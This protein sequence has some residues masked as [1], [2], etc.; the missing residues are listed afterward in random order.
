M[1]IIGLLLIAISIALIIWARNNEP[2]RTYEDLRAPSYE[3]YDNQMRR[4]FRFFQDW[5]IIGLR[6][7]FGIYGV[8]LGII[9]IIIGLLK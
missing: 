9:L 1:I 8:I 5:R 6:S 2:E 4:T 7:K 3:S